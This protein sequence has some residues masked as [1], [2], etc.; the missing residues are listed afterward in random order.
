MQP[1]CGNYNQLDL[2]AGTDVFTMPPKVAAAGRKSLSGSFTDHTHEN[3]EVSLY[4]SAKGA[5]IEKFWEVDDKVLSFA[6]RVSGKIPLTGTELTRIAHEE[7]C[8]DIFPSLT[9][10]EKATIAADGKIPVFSKWQQQIKDGKI[11]PDTLLT[12]GRTGIIYCRSADARS[13]NT[14]HHQLIRV[15]AAVQSHKE[16]SRQ[17]PKH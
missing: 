4:S 12:S 15:I 3:Y 1:A 5:G 9:K 16:E 7:G 8:E 6:Q 11:A 13:A 14:E 17:Q 10:E 2:L